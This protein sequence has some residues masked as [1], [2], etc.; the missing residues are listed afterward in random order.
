[1][2]KYKINDKVFVPVERVAAGTSC[3]FPVVTGIVDSIKGRSVTVNCP[4]GIGLQEI[5]SSAVHS[6]S[7]SVCIIRV[8][9]FQ[10]EASL[11]DPITKSI[12][13]F[14]RL[15]ISDDQVSLNYVR[16]LEE[17]LDVFNR[18]SPSFTHYIIVGH[19]SSSGNL[20]FSLGE[21]CSAKKLADSMTTMTTNTH[22]FLWLCCHSGD[23]KFARP[24]SAAPFCRNHVGSYRALNG[25]TASHFAQAFF[26]RHLLQGCSFRIAFKKALAGLPTTDH[27]RH[28][29]AGV[30]N[31][32]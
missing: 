4:Y 6:A 28:W 3:P 1:M 8:G 27:F 12:R 5:A 11:L 14:L 16:S 25:A 20:I 19:G 31:S 18:T 2:A 10:T 24:L 23:A 29:M 22:D 9:D 21:Y 13:H 7:L 17:F 15:L 30:H 32:V 26:I